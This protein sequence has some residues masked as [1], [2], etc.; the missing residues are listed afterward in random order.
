[1]YG[2]TYLL[3]GE[4]SRPHLDFVAAGLYDSRRT[5]RNCF[6]SKRF[7]HVSSSRIVGF[8][9]ASGIRVVSD[10]DDGND[11]QR[12]LTGLPLRVRMLGPFEVFGQAGW[13]PGPTL[14][15]GGQLT[16]MLVSSPTAS[17]T[18][19]EIARTL[20]EGLPLDVSRHRIHMA[21]SGARCY[22]RGVLGGHNAIRSTRNGYAL[23]SGIRVESDVV[24]FDQAYEG[25]TIEEMRLAVG[26]Y[27]GEFLSG[28]TASW[29]LRRRA[30]T[31][32]RYAEMVGRLASH[33]F[34][35]GRYNDALHYA[36]LLMAAD[37]SNERAA[38]MV[39]R[40]LAALDLRSAAIAE[41]GWLCAFLKTNMGAR[42]NPETRR[43]YYALADESE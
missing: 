28:E 41:F 35:S 7:T 23:Q 26:L 40:C 38:R 5:R 27:R 19:A 21:A 4:T 39:M 15:K 43:L 22:L 24:A 13:E 33:D 6:I 10:H 18:E 14:A 11:G 12:P 37:G 30:E 36:E 2:A 16:R 29:L 34:D 42:P 1:M 31:I 32:G 3:L 25:G 17:V 9:F 8:S 20:P